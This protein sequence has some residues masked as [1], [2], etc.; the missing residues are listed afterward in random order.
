METSGENSWMM[1]IQLVLREINNALVINH[2]C[3][4]VGLLARKIMPIFNQ[5]MVVWVLFCTY[6]EKHYLKVGK[7]LCVITPSSCFE[8]WRMGTSLQ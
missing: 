8:Q 5:T 3:C 2:H 7:A 1:Y 6:R 4:V